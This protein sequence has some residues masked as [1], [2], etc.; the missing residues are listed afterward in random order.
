MEG[1][2]AGIHNVEQHVNQLEQ[3]L[4]DCLTHKADAAEVPTNYQ[5]SAHYHSSLQPPPPFPLSPCPATPQDLPMQSG[6]KHVATSMFDTL[7]DLCLQEC[8]GHNALKRLI[9]H[10]SRPS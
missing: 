2:R 9:A 6:T 1:P 5:V 10:V 8:S 7:K 3:R 4:E